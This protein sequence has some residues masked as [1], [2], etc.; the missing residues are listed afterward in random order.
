MFGLFVALGIAIL[1][2]LAILL[3]FVPHLVQ[4]Q[5]LRTASESAQLREMLVDMINEQEAVAM[6]QAQ[7]VTSISYLQDQLEQVAS[8][9]TPVAPAPIVV[10]QSANPEAL[11]ELD[12]DIQHLHIQ[13][14]TYM[15]TA[16][17]HYQRDSEAW[18]HLVSLLAA[19]QGRLATL[20][21]EE[22]RE[23]SDAL[24][25]ATSERMHRLPQRQLSDGMLMQMA[26]SSENH[27]IRFDP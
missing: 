3:W 7:L 27:A 25:T 2:I 20:S 18:L 8:S 26:N 1:T 10:D 13:L 19:I 16:R 6:R 23:S 14:D 22:A 17:M 4:Q 24:A 5:A 9:H 15:R 12:Q 21:P 11:Q